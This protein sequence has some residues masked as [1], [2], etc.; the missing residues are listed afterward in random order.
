VAKRLAM[1]ER[2]LQRRLAEAGTSYVDLLSE[3]RSD[4][5]KDYLKSSRTSLTEI[6]WLLGF[7]EQSAFSRAFKRWTGSSPAQYRKALSVAN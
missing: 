5:A 7:S 3:V 1:S 6:A 4:L 2:T